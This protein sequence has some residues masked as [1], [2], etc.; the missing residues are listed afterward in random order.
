VRALAEHYGQ[1]ELN[2]ALSDAL[3]STFTVTQRGA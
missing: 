1:P 3:P 2:A